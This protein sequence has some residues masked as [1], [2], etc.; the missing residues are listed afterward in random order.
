MKSAMKALS[1]GIGLLIWSLACQATDLSDELAHS[2]DFQ[3]SF[4]Q[5]RLNPTALSPTDLNQTASNDAAI[6]LAVLQHMQHLMGLPEP[7][8]EAQRAWTEDWQR[9]GHG[10]IQHTA[11]QL[12]VRA[13]QRALPTWS[14]WLMLSQQRQLYWLSQQQ[15]PACSVDG[16]FDGIDA[17][18]LAA[19][20]LR[21]ER[22]DLLRQ[23]IARGEREAT[24][25]SLREIPQRFDQTTAKQLLV[26]AAQ[27]GD[28]AVA[29]MP[30][31]ATH[32]GPDDDVQQ[33][34]VDGLYDERIGPVS[35]V[36]LAKYGSQQTL[37]ELH[38][39]LQLKQLDSPADRFAQ[40]AIEQSGY[41][42]E[43]LALRHR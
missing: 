15:F 27:Q 30:V 11:E 3:Q 32:F 34:M 35:A 40:L 25:N 17:T 26:E 5:A 42:L 12:L 43:P 4:A 8:T 7:L 23:V 31:L 29:A 21:C 22:A 39:K 9:S 1:V 28:L 16:V 38:R 14:D 10:L 6:E 36:S 33:L 20:A 19:L 41:V 13:K 18:V 24:L 37:Q 2:T